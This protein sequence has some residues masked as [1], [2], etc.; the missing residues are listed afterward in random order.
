[1]K[2]EGVSDTQPVA[3]APGGGKISGGGDAPRTGGP[4][5]VVLAQPGAG[6]QS[7]EQLADARYF[8]GAGAVHDASAHLELFEIVRLQTELLGR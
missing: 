6:N 4:S 2:A 8:A 3:H 1:M 7:V 5:E